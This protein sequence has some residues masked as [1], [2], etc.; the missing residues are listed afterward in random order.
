M[1]NYT[2]SVFIYPPQK[3]KKKILLVVKKLLA[4]LFELSLLSRVFSF[5]H[6]W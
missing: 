2:L 4:V 3:K 6:E 5:V 1:C